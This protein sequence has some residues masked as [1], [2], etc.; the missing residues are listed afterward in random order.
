MAGVAF[1]ATPDRTVRIGPPDV[2]APETSRL[3]RSG[4]FEQGECIWGAIDGAGMVPLAERDLVSGQPCRPAHGRPGRQRMPTPRELLVLG[5]VARLTVQRCDLACQHEGVVLEIVLTVERLV[6]VVAGDVGLA[7]LA[8]FELVDDCRG[9][10]PVALR[11]P[12]GGPRESREWVARVTRRS[13]AVD[14]Q[15]RYDQAAPDHGRNEDRPEWHVAGCT[16]RSRRARKTRRLGDAMS[17]QQ[18]SSPWYETG[19]LGPTVM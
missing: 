12:A 17:D 3:D 16:Q 6:T 18:S 13:G 4:S 7:V 9:F 11:A 14:H 19:R 1:C 5:T 15:R 2:V 8:A 10:F